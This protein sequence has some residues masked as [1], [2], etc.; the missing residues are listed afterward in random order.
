MGTGSVGTGSVVAGRVGAGP[1]GAGSM[2]AG[3]LSPETD[4]PGSS[5]GAPSLDRG[6]GA[7][8]GRV[9]GRTQ[10][11]A[12]G[13]PPRGEDAPQRAVTGAARVSAAASVAEAVKRAVP[14]PGE[15]MSG[16]RGARTELRNQ[17]RSRRRLRMVTLVSLAVVV[18]VVL[19][20]FFGLRSA[21]KDPVFGS[22]DALK[23]PSWAATKVVDRSSGSRWCFIDCRFRERDVASRRPFKETTAVYNAALVAAG[24]QSWKVGECPDQPVDPAS[25]TYS[26]WKRDEFT[27]D[28]RVGLPDCAV[29]ALAAQV[30]G[31][32]PSAPAIPPDPAKCVG[33]AVSIKVQNAISDTRGKREP[34][35]SPDLVGET[36]D[37]VLSNDPLLAPTPSAS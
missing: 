30:P 11:S 36:P 25:S 2:S 35:Q 5:G 10:T 13:V 8:G 4:V 16:L 28:L 22:L 6:N 14:G 1:L 20:A 37:P 29:D 24:W 26:C 9:D 19:P 21:T 17:M 15:T 32:L 31:A 12:P 27:L 34:R 18:L 7:P 3:T 23:V 33:S